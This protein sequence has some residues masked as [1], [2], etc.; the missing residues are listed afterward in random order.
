MSTNT[1]V[2]PV[3]QTSKANRTLIAGLMGPSM[4][5]VLNMSMFG[6][7]LPT[8]RDTLGL[9]ADTV[10]WLVVAYSLTFAMFMPLYGRLGDALGKKRLLLGG[11]NVFLVGTIVILLAPNF[12]FLLLG[13]VIQGL[14]VAG[15]VPLGIAIISQRFD[16]SQRGKMLGTWNSA[17]PATASVAPLLAGFIID[18]IV[19]RAI[20]W[21]V[22]LLGVVAV[23][24]IRAWV[25]GSTTRPKAGFLKTFDWGGFVLLAGTMISLVFFVSSR[26]ITG[27]E[28]LQ[29]WRLLG[30]AI[31]FLTGLVVWERRR[32]EP[33]LELALFKLRIFTFSSVGAGIRMFVMSSV[34]F[35]LPLYLTDVY[36]LNA[37]M[38]GFMLTIHAA[39]L[40]VTMRLG[41]QLADQWGSRRPVVIGSAVQGSMMLYFAFLPAELPL[42]IAV[43]GIVIHGLGAGLSLAALH[44]SAM[45]PIPNEQSG[46]AAGVYSMIRFAGMMLGTSVSGVFLQFGLDQ[47]QVVVDA[48]QAVFGLVALVAFGGV[49]IGALFLKE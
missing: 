27:V 46:A 25:P 20:F 45:G 23:L 15:I 19:W 9:A 28:P 5:M 32:F 47:G 30:L 36:H 7:A 24:A 8:I 40:L 3:V 10:A 6:V 22:L 17:G 16:A 31:T 12:Q 14:G 35:L 26:P 21:P 48:Y 2:T 1:L 44:R 37:A 39:A 13:R 4:M 41:G 18:H 49:V 34:G 29:D 38:T 43:V 42:S 33:F 11:V